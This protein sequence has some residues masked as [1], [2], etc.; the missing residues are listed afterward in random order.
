MKIYCCE[1]KK[2]VKAELITADKIYYNRPDLGAVYMWQCPKCSSFVGTHK[3]SKKHSPL[4]SMCDARLRNA[5]K[6]IHELLDP[7]W[8]DLKCSRKEVYKKI[9]KEI[10]HEYHTGEIRSI[11]DAKEV[12]RIILRIKREVENE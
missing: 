11:E 6:K 1:C 8:R 7:L 5:R 10:G 12:Y 3:N 4:G 2:W 9:S